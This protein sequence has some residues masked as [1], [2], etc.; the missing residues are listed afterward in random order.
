MSFFAPASQYT[1]NANQTLRVYSIVEIN[2]IDNVI[3]I[4]VFYDDE[5]I[6][7]K[8]KIEKITDKGDYY[9]L[10][11]LAENYS[12]SIID[13]QKSGIWVKRTIKHNGII[14]KFFNNP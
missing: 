5:T 6:K 1:K 14:H 11:C 7:S 13:I 3:T 8:Y 4:S 9:S 2:Q 12:T 10:Q